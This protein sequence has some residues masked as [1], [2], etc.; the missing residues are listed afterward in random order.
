MALYKVPLYSRQ[1]L[2]IFD[3]IQLFPRARQAIKELVADDR[4]DYIETGSLIGIRRN[5][6]DILLPSE[7][8][9]VQMEPSATENC[10][11]FYCSKY[12]T[13]LLLPCYCALCQTHLVQK[14][15]IETWLT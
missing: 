12:T 3:E 13:L 9:S 1:S 14:Q 6:Q 2:L 10:S 8:L 7:E 11:T 15:T 5:V 4:Y